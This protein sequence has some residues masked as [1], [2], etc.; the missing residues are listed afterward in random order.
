MPRA[1][2]LTGPSRSAELLAERSWAHVTPRVRAL[3]WDFGV[4]TNLRPIGQH[5]DGVFAAM[6]AA[7]DPEHWYSFIVDERAGWTRHR[8]YRDG[9]RLLDTPDPSRAFL[10][11]LW[12]INQRVFRGTNDK[13]LVHASV[14]SSGDRAVV[15]TAP[16]ESGKSTLSLGLV[17]RGL[18]YLTDEAAAIDLESLVVHPFPKAVSVDVGA[19]AFLEHLR[20]PSDPAIAEYLQGQWQVTPDAIRFGAVAG[21]AV[22]AW[23]VVPR[24]VRDAETVLEPMTRADAL[25]VLLEQALNL[26]VHGRAAFECLAAVVRRCRCFRLVMGDLP[27]ACD[28]MLAMLAEGPGDD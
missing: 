1:D 12:D 2:A 26:H 20:P 11:L 9:D 24:Y 21:P 17:E 27:S 23:I 6:T 25:G 7:G 14:V 4:R 5:L 22:P 10:Y 8:L 16:S 15:M 18:G 28:T 13:A 19:Q 3:G